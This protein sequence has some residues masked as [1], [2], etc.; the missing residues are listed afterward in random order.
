MYPLHTLTTLT[1]ALL[2]LALTLQSTGISHLYR[3]HQ[4]TEIADN[5]AILTMTRREET[6]VVIQ[7]VKLGFLRSRVITLP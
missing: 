2:L 1:F 4:Q 3:Q 7:L 6:L 5:T